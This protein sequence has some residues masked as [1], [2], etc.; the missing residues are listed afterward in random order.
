MDKLYLPKE[1]NFF[2]LIVI[3]MIVIRSN[4]KTLTFYIL[5]VIIRFDNKMWEILK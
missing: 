4:V 2:F 5:N 1:K 3:V